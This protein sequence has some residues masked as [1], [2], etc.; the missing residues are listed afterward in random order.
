MKE[1]VILKMVRVQV[2][3]KN[4]RNLSQ[5][6]KFG[7]QFSAWRF[8][9][10]EGNVHQQLAMCCYSLFLPSL[11][12]SFSPAPPFLFHL[13]R[14]KGD[15]MHFGNMPL[16]KHESPAHSGYVRAGAEGWPHDCWL[17]CSVSCS[18]LTCPALYLMDDFIPFPVLYSVTFVL[19]E[20][21]FNWKKF[22]H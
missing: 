19:W 2:H 10:W 21:F 6:P 17:S 15:L 5:K 1:D 22:W 13:A 16:D 7:L 20:H 14:V 8:A 12:L 11:S 3:H 9:V 18:M 4:L